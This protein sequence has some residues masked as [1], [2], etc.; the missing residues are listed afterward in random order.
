MPAGAPLLSPALE[1]CSE[2]LRGRDEWKSNFTSM[3]CTRW[4]KE[5]MREKARV[6]GNSHGMGGLSF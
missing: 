1:V 4:K 2:G 3:V 5:F 6:E